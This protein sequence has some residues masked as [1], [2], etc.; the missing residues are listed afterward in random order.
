MVVRASARS[1]PR[2]RSGGCSFPQSILPRLGVRIPSTA[3]RTVAPEAVTR[4]AELW[5]SV[6][7]SCLRVQSAH[8]TLHQLEVLQRLEQLAAQIEGSAVIVLWGRDVRGREWIAN[9]LR[10]SGF[11]VVLVHPY[12][13]ALLFSRA[14]RLRAASVHV[15]LSLIARGRG[16]RKRPRAGRTSVAEARPVERDGCAEAGHGARA[17]RFVRGGC[18][19]RRR[20]DLR[21]AARHGRDPLRARADRKRVHVLPAGGSQSTH[22]TTG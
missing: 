19:A 20:R 3:A 12:L 9:L 16:S 11:K 13:G 7:R 21:A 14:L 5:R 10:A 22:C 8:A 15:V 1:S 4:I 2:R 6:D 17:R 18:G